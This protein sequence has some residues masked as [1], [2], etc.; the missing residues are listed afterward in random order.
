MQGVIFLYRRNRVW[1]A[2]LVGFGLGVLLG[3]RLGGGFLCT[4]LALGSVA[5]GILLAQ[6]QV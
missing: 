6:K 1:C 2:A 5:L 3:A 4:C